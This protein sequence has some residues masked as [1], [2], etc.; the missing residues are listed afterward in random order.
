MPLTR[1]ANSAIDTVAAHHGAVA[2][3]LARYAETDLLC[4]RAAAPAALAERQAAAWDPWLAWAA[5]IGA[6]LRVTA[7]V[8]AVA[9][10]AESLARLAAR[11]A[12]RDAFALAGL[13]EAVTLTGSLVL[14]LAVAEGVLAAADAFAL[15]RL[16]EDWQA[17]LWGRDEEAAE[18]VAARARAM[19]DA[20]RFLALLGR[21]GADEAGRGAGHP[22]IS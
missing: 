18:V 9:Q 22:H 8:V 5:G 21:T 11:V 3:D 20:G 19:E 13:H 2:A 1:T 14:G 17:A 4:H 15:S 7:G 10:P 12:A 16:D 6:P